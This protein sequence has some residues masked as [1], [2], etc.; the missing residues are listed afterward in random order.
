MTAIKIATSKE[1][2]D[3]LN[4]SVYR[5]ILEEYYQFPVQN[6]RQLRNITNSVQISY[7]HNNY[8]RGPVLSTRPVS[9]QQHR[10]LT[11]NSPAFVP[12]RVLFANFEEDK[13]KRKDEKEEAH[14]HKMNTQGVLTSNS[15]ESLSFHTPSRVVRIKS[16]RGT[17]T[18]SCAQESNTYIEDNK[19]ELDTDYSETHDE[20]YHIENSLEKEREKERERENEYYELQYKKPQKLFTSPLD[21]KNFV[22][23]YQKKFKTEVFLHT[24]PKFSIFS[25]FCFHYFARF[26][27]LLICYA[28]Y[29]F[30]NKLLLIRFSFARILKPME[31]VNLEIN[32]LLLMAEKKLEKKVICLIII[33]QDFANNFTRICIVHMEIDANFYILT[34]KN[35]FSFFQYLLPFYF[36]IEFQLILISILDVE[37]KLKSS[38]ISSYLK[39]I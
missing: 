25:F 6:A 31:D 36:K 19:Y 13:S 20:R 28:S 35:L 24:T 30:L 23:N 38:L 32:A 10:N 5:N 12:S 33:S 37:K 27:C 11:T 34:G 17:N 14:L 26:F 1:S 3:L 22:D 29:S 21:K 9:L 18:S 16:R 2:S 7:N 39:K 15:L 4:T 8:Q